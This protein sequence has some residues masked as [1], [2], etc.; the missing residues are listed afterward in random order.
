M[1]VSLGVKTQCGAHYHVPPH[2]HMCGVAPGVV[3]AGGLPDNGLA[4]GEGRHRWAA[5]ASLKRVEGM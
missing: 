5:M 2:V 3:V 1:T 4:E